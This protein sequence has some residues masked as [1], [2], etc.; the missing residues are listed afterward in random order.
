L[1]ESKGTLGSVTKEVVDGVSDLAGV[2]TIK[3]EW[4]GV[5]RIIERAID[6]VIDEIVRPTVKES[7]TIHRQ[8][9]D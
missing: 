5:G 1:E 9:A 3:G 4:F 8:K 6:D 2:D 7:M